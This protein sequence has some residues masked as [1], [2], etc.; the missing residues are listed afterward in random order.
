MNVRRL[1]CVFLLGIVTVGVLGGCAAKTPTPVQH[2]VELEQLDPDSPF[3][4]YDPWERMNRTVYDF[5]ARLD[6]YVFMPVVETYEILTPRPVQTGLKNFFNNIGEVPTFINCVLQGDVE[7]AATTF[8]RFVTNTT[9]GIGGLFDIAERG[10]LHEQDED[11]G[12]T[13]ATWGVPRG[14]Y[15][16]VPVF[17]PSSVRDAAGLAVDGVMVWVEEDAVMDYLDPDYTWSFRLSY[18]TLK[19]IDVRKSVLFHYY[20][21]GSLFE[22]DMVRF[23]YSKK[24]E[25]DI[26]K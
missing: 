2:D 20:E 11:F 7:G 21:D 22:Y 4:V 13:L 8:G 5:N 15:L 10:G 1:L 19:G 17:G 9:V 24:R 6:H 23:L 3:Y 18:V 12:Q 25:W 14:P 26:Q 16:V